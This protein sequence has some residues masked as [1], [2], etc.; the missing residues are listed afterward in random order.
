ML[1]RAKSVF[2]LQSMEDILESYI[3]ILYNL[4]NMEVPSYQK[5]HNIY[6][7][8]PTWILSGSIG[9]PC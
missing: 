1:Y 9:V 5:Q 2:Y 4:Y 3:D 8:D 7:P 6:T